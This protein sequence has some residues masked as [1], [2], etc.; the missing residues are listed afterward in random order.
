M[1]GALSEPNFKV[2]PSAL[3]DDLTFFPRKPIL[4]VPGSADKTITHETDKV[5]K[6]FTHVAGHFG[7]PNDVCLLAMPKL[8]L[9]R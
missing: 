6:Y 5:R 2:T 9:K 4:G 1:P 3:L 8:F 7:L